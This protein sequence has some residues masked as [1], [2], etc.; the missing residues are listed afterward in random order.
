MPATDKVNILLVDDQPAKLLSYE[1][2]LHELDENLL[3]ANSAQEAF[4]HLLRTDV[5]VVLVDVVM[6]DLDGFQLAKMI[7]EHP[8][9]QRTA[10]IFIS[11]VL[12]NDLDFLRGYELGAVDYVSVP[13]VPEILRA[14]VRVFAELYRKTQQLEQLNRTLERRVAERT[15]ELEDS[16]TA[17][18]NSEERLRLAFEAARMGWWDYDIAADQVSWSPSLTRIMG[19]APESFGSTLAGAAAHV[20]PDDREKFMALV[21]QGIGADGTQTCELRFIR[22]DGSIRWSLAAG[23]V[24]R[25]AAGAPQRFA[26]VDLDI[27]ERKRAEERQDVLVRELDHRA[28][29]LLAVVQSVLRLS[30]ADTVREFVAALEGRIWALSRA[31]TLL[32]ESRWH[33]VELGRIVAEETAPFAS[34]QGKRVEASGPAVSLLPA[35]AQSLALALHELVTNAVKH[36]GLSVPDGRVALTWRLEPGALVISWIETGGPPT[37]PPAR[38]GFGTK[39]IDASVEHQLRGNATFAWRETG[40][41]CTISIPLSNLDLPKGVAE[42]EPAADGNGAGAVTF[43]IAASRVL[44]VEDEALIAMM[45]VDALQDLGLEVVGPFRT[46]PQALAAARNERLDGAILD[47]NVA[48]Q[49]V[50][51]VADLLSARRIPFVFLTGYSIGGIDRRYANVPVLEKPIESKLLRQLF[52]IGMKAGVAEGPAASASLAG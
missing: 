17:L 45:M 37:S 5:A 7:R 52:L 18:R 27:T 3:M 39:L 22:A 1:T 50:Y 31:H 40:L 19:F 32:S 34:P 16:M 2:I 29:N 28:K 26:G 42:P 35:T 33:A 10:I 38:R 8:R 6:P 20:H 11:A 13:V 12:L 21:N 14:K 15:A 30:K 23:Q 46:V 44:L 51:P 25:N 9:F 41:N 4:E 24:I 47:V 49:Q 36:G 43:P 48:G